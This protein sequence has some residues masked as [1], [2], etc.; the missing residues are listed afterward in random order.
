[1]LRK[2]D[3][4]GSIELASAESG[5]NCAKTSVRYVRILAGL[6]VSDG[7]DW[8]QF[9]SHSLPSWGAFSEGKDYPAAQ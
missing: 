1:M 2:K 8:F 6:N 7:D 9:P 3:E 4:Q 5:N